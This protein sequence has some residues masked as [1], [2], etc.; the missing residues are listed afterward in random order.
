MIKKQCGKE[1]ASKEVELT[2]EQLEKVSGGLE[3][4]HPE[5]VCPKCGS[6]NFIMKRTGMCRC[7]D[8]GATFK[9]MPLPQSDD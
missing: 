4:N 5:I 2:D 8:C 1:Q 6:T 7:Y 9:P 3:E